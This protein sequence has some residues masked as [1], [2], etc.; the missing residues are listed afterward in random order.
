MYPA[1]FD[2]I[3]AE[4]L[5]A[6]RWEGGLVRSKRNGTGVVVVASRW[7]P[8]RDDRGV[9]VGIL[10]TNSDITDRKRAEDALRRQANLLEQSMPASCGS[11]RVQSSTKI[12]AQSRSMV[13]P[14]K[15]PSAV[16]AMIS[17]GQNT[18]D[19]GGV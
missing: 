15:R 4:V 14:A 1:P 6:G 13:S 19:E 8:Q 5:R 11:S 12:A 18:D 3:D 7:S 17:C 9:P 2:Q 10:E 16:A